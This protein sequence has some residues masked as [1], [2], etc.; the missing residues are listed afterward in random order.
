MSVKSGIRI[1]GTKTTK[2]VQDQASPAERERER[3]EAKSD[4]QHANLSK[5][6]QTEDPN[7]WLN[8]FRL[9]LQRSSRVLAVQ[10]N[11]AKQKFNKNKMNHTM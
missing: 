4:T 8:P 6:S 9:A 11:A 10:D 3:H 5:N 2:P 7:D 1:A